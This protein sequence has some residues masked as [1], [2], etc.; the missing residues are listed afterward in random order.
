MDKETHVA[1]LIALAKAD[2]VLHAHELIFIQGLALRMGVDGQS[3]QRIVK[4]PDVVPQ[5]IPDN[6]N[7][8][9]RQLG[10]LIALMH[11]DFN[12]DKEELSFVERIGV[13]LGFKSAEVDQLAE[14]LQSNMLPA[15]NET[16]K[17]IIN[18]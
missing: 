2:G 15:D 6:E 9:L 11:I 7:D 18:P 12:A 4:Y 1:N 10:E 17:K 14:F 3:F 8:R 5:R 13:R 16:L